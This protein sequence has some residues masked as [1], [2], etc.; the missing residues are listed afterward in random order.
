MALLVFVAGAVVYVEPAS[1]LPIAILSAIAGVITLIL[2]SVVDGAG[3]VI[4]E[5]FG[6]AVDGSANVYVTGLFSD[7]AFKVTPS[8]V[9]TQII[10]AAGEQSNVANA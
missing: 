2:D 7:N 10:D 5:M 3:H 9:I 4:D 6:I 1:A 8:G